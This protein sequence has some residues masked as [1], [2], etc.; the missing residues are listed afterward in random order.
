MS[1][2]PHS[3]CASEKA[4]WPLEKSFPTRILKHL[5]M[6]HFDVYLIASNSIRAI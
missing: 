4:D 2:P 1:Y 6:N 5:I 3:N